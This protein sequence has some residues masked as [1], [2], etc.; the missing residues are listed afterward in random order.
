MKK[1]LFITHENI[2]DTPVA[3]AMFFD[4]YKDINQKNNFSFLSAHPHNKSINS[5]NLLFFTRKQKK[6]IN[7][8]DMISFF[9]WPVKNLS[10]FYSFDI[11]ICR[12]YPAAMLVWI[13]TAFFKNK[14][15]IIDTRGLFFDE[16]I[17]SGTI[18][19]KILVSILRLVEKRIL[20]KSSY[21]IAVSLAQKDFYVKNHSI[22]PSKITVIHNGA[23]KSLITENKITEG[24]INLLYIGSFIDW[25]CPSE[26]L[27]LFDEISKFAETE[28]TIYTKDIKFAKRIFGLRRNITI[29][30]LNFRDKPK[31]FDLGF[32]LIKGGVSK[33]ICFPVKLCEYINSGTKVLISN[34]I[35]EINN[36]E[37]RAGLD[38]YNIDI[39]D[40]KNEIVNIIE[41]INSNKS[42]Y[43][44]LPS[45]LTFDHQVSMY[46]NLLSIMINK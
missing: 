37:L 42:Y 39:H 14:N 8:K 25:H 6:G 16:L 9:T 10:L 15:Y 46:K 44:D 26:L 20:K 18:N 23:P 24:K 33:E 7:I 45:N 30:T 13:Y 21:V 4:I 40:L 5:E 35:H 34:N 17:D 1:A 29:Q 41:Y 28:L 38:F 2:D 31:R 19:S 27:T 22:N 11:F 12:S 32:C 36:L 3:K 43:P